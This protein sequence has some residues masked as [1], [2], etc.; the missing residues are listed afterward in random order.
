[1]KKITLHLHTS[2]IGRRPVSF[3]QYFPQTIGEFFYPD[4]Y[5]YIYTLASRKKNIKELVK[6]VIVNL[7]RS[8]FNASNLFEKL[9][10]LFT[11]VVVLPIFF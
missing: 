6:I 2:Y 1:M 3:H 10:I 7:F 5:I 11:I 4:I 8:L 9:F